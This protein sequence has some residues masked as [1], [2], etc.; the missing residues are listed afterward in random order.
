MCG[1]EASIQLL[2]LQQVSPGV[3]LCAV[4]LVTQFSS[5][6]CSAVACV[7]SVLSM[8]YAELLQGH[9]LL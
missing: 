6:R 9:M 2:K 4:V 7:G 5:G 3:W 8:G 1:D